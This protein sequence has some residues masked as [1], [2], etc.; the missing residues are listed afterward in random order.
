MQTRFTHVPSR[1]PNTIVSS[2]YLMHAHVLQKIIIIRS[3]YF[4]LVIVVTDFWGTSHSTREVTPT[5]NPKWMLIILTSSC[6]DILLES[7]TTTDRIFIC[8]EK[9]NKGSAKMYW[10]ENV[11]TEALPWDKRRLSNCA[12]TNNCSRKLLASLFARWPNCGAVSRHSS[13]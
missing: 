6:R 1:V 11:G 9:L 7:T 2:F 12:E 10:M 3:K 13:G 4:S 8:K 5:L